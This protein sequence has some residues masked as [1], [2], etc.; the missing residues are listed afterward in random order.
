M[1]PMTMMPKIIWPVARSAWRVDDHVADA[2]GRADEL[3]DDDVGPGPAEHE[4]QD[5]GDLR[6]VRR[7]QHAAHD[8]L[9]RGAERIGGLDEVAPR[10]ADRDRD[11]EH[12]LEHRADEDDEELLGLADAGPQDQSGTKAEAGR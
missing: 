11:H 8:A 6:R 1:R 3:G 2:G 7:D 5:L 12:D 9:R 10:L 4:A